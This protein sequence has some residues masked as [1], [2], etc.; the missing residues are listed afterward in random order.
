MK[1]WVAG[2]GGFI[3]RAIAAAGGPDIA[4]F[5]HDDAGPR[6]KPGCLIYAGRNPL[7]GQQGYGIENDKELVWAQWAARNRTRFVHLGSRKVYAPSPHPLSENSEIGPVDLYG[8]HKL[9]MEQRL[10]AVLGNQLLIL[11]IANAFGYERGRKSFMGAML[12]GLASNGRIT[13]DMNPEIKRDFLPAGFV[14]S[15][16]LALAQVDAQGIVNIGSG[17]GT[18]TGELAD[19]VIEG[20]GGGELVISD[21]RRHDAFVLD[22]MQLQRL[23]GLTIGR[24]DI[25]TKVIGLGRRLRRELKGERLERP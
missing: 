12:D 14:A 8:E 5:A 16:A 23:T 3:G 6:E 11:R 19:A 17:R 1:I 10:R 20:F 9:A 21:D 15:A 22:T 7:L 13:F 24:N 18:A 25:L 4:A 2:A